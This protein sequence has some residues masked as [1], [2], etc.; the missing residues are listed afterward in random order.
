MWTGRWAASQSLGTLWGEHSS[1]EGEAREAGRVPGRAKG[2]FVPAVTWAPP[3][4]SAGSW[5]TSG[6]HPRPTGPACPCGPKT[7]PSLW[8]LQA[9][10][11][12]TH[13]PASSGP[14]L[15]H[16]GPRRSHSPPAS[17]WGQYG[18]CSTVACGS[19]GARSAGGLVWEGGRGRASPLR[20]RTEHRSAPIT[21]QLLFAL[22]SGP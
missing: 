13:S 12:R 11:E 5:L 18:R 1:L 10:Q 4:S 3:S 8:L 2:P 9:S 21:F 17:P 14:S 7:V 6:G 19:A 16:P 22:T 20:G 15:R